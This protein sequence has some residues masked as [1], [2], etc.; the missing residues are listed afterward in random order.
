MPQVDVDEDEGMSPNRKSPYQAISAYLRSADMAFQLWLYRVSILLGVPH[1]LLELVILVPVYLIAISLFVNYFLADKALWKQLFEFEPVGEPVEKRVIH[2]AYEL[3]V[4]GHRF[5][6]KNLW[7]QKQWEDS[8]LY[9]DHDRMERCAWLD[10]EHTLRRFEKEY[11]GEPLLGIELCLKRKK[12]VFDIYEDQNGTCA[13]E[14]PHDN[15]GVEIFTNEDHFKFDPDPT[16]AYIEE[17]G[18]A[19]LD[20]AGSG[21]GVQY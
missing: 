11:A 17:L 18:A 21:G 20:R 5:Q 19:A 12:T 15:S 10:V 13:T 6:M 3:T 1:A 4:E 7:Y 14:I 16:S 9:S 2:Y 8:G